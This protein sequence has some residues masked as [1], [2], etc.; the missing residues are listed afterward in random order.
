MDSEKSLQES[1]WTLFN[2]HRYILTNSFVFE[3][4]SD[5]FSVTKTGTVYEVEIKIS[6]A[7]Y[8]K[9]FEKE[10]HVLFKNLVDK[11]R[12]IVIREQGRSWPYGDEL[13]RI[14]SYSLNLD[15]W[16]LKTADTSFTNEED[17][18]GYWHLRERYINLNSR[19]QR[20]HAATS[21]I[22]I[23]DL[24][25]KHIPNRFY[26]ACPE[27]LIKKEDVPVYAGLI[28]VKDGWAKIIKQ[29]PFMIKAD[30][31]SR[32][33]PIL[34]DKFYYLSVDYRFKFRLQ[35]IQNKEV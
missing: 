12:F 14:D 5:F 22:R 13:F 17:S 31:L 11:K 7:D 24:E 6:K 8:K 30:T 35:E 19:I 9:D 4:E 3:W 20:I 15:H 32:I 21:S 25:K 1:V 28:W 18:M 27:G 26:Y 16:K 23:I 10:K 34:L 2:N 33:K 29:A